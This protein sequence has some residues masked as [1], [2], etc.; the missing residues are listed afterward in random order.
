MQVSIII[1]AYNEEKFIGSVLKSIPRAY[2]TI[3]VDDGSTDKTKQAAEKFPQVKVITHPKKSGKGAAIKTGIKN[4]TGE[5]L[6]FLDGD[7][8]FNSSEIQKLITPIQENK[9]DLVLGVRDF[10]LIPLKRRITNE[11]TRFA[12]W[13]ITDKKFRDPL[14]GFRAVTRDSIKSIELIGDDFRTETEMLIK[15]KKT[16]CRITETPV[17]I[18]YKANK[19]YFSIRDG[20]KLVS[21]LIMMLI[22]SRLGD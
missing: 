22:T 2:E 12:M 13:L 17:S 15:L 18:N 14:V 8:Q 6:V 4:S 9:A 3:V 7:G 5:V 11:L 10:N 21:F 20:I 1:P 16:G 19:S